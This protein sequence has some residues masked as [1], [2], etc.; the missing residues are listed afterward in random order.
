M[1]RFFPFS[2][3]PDTRLTRLC[4]PSPSYMYYLC[5]AISFPFLHVPSPTAAFYLPILLMRCLPLDTHLSHYA[6]FLFKYINSSIVE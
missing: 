3:L 4:T 2:Y 1:L 6:A 5:A